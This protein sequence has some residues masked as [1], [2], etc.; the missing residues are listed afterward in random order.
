[1]SITPTNNTMD[2]EY[3]LTI[4]FNDETRTILSDSMEFLI[5]IGTEGL[6]NNRFHSATI[7]R[8][9]VDATHKD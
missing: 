6:E 4:T 9:V 2:Y 3:I 1:M 5:A 8:G 7:T